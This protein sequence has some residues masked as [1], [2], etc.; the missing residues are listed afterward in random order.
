VSNVCQPPDAALELPAG[1]TDEGSVE[2]GAR[3]DGEVLAVQLAKIDPA[4]PAMNCDPDGRC[5]VPRNGEVLGKRIGGTRRNDRDRRR[6]TGD[7]VH[8]PLDHP[9][10]APDD[11]QLDARL[12]RPARLLTRLAGPAHLEPQRI[13]DTLDREQLTKLA[14]PTR[15]R[16]LPVCN[17]RHP[18]RSTISMGNH[19]TD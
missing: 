6:G 16:L 13:V 15:K 12:D 14:E 7:R 1:V 10:A 5:Q 8:A 11:D 2:P 17:D 19:G 4:G 9:V 3:H 18:A